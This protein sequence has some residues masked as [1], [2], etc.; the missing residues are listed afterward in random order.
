[1]SATLN[2]DMTV[3]TIATEVPG[4]AGVFERL[5]IDYCCAGKVPLAQACRK[6]GL[7]VEEVVTLLRSEA[8][9]SGA[10][11]RDWSGATMTELAD[12]I[13]ATHHAYLKTELPRLC[14][15][16]DKVGTAH[17]NGCPELRELAALFRRFSE[18]MTRHM[19][20]EERDIFPALRSMERGSGAA[21]AQIAPPIER[22]TEEHEEAGVALR[23]FRQL[24]RNYQ[25]P[26]G[27]CT[28]WRVLLTDLERLERDMHEHVHKENNVLFPRAMSTAGSA[29]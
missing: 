1:M 4:A 14:V 17:G 5:G 19:A 27:A 28:S 3:G 20:E 10:H 25:P 8:A 13:E 23:R 15:L 12:E 2:P 16:A 21:A 6:R 29:R 22:M 18:E 11:S 24:T 26:L 7:A 9:G